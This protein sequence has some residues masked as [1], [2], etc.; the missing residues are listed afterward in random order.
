MT[1]LLAEENES[2]NFTLYDRDLTQVTRRIDALMMVLKSC[3]ED[4]CIDPW[5]TL[6]P[7][8]AVS[9]LKD[10]LNERFDTFYKD[11]VKV[12]YEECSRGY[13]PDLEGPQE[14]NVYGEEEEMRRSF[15]IRS[16]WSEWI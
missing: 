12:R 11:Q 13:F 3:K 8:G 4:T 1:N 16:D 7:G 2:L 9:S 6:H 5:G 15:F 14:Y 10:A